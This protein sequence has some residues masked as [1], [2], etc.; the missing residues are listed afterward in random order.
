MPPQAMP[1]EA[2]PDCAESGDIR[3]PFGQM[4]DIGRSALGRSR[5]PDHSAL[6]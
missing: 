4:G 6:M 2:P 3:A 1:V 5:H